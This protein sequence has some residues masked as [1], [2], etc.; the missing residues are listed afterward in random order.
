MTINSPAHCYL[1]QYFLQQ[2]RQL[3]YFPRYFHFQSVAKSFVAA[4]SVFVVE[5]GFLHQFCNAYTALVNTYVSQN[6]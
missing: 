6:L 5:L 4:Y 1:L 3:Q 2:A